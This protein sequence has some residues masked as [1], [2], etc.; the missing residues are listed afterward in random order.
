VGVNAFHPGGAMSHCQVAQDLATFPAG[1][2]LKSGFLPNV[3]AGLDTGTSESPE[4]IRRLCVKE[5]GLQRLEFYASDQIL[6]KHFRN[7]R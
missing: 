3:Q 1:I 4:W 6:L 7:L 2:S 5:P